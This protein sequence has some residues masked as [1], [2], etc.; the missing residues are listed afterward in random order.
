M[1][2]AGDGLGLSPLTTTNGGGEARAVRVR[3]RAGAREIVESR[4]LA[5][6]ER[7]ELAA[8]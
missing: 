8:R 7:W 5:S 2:A 3:F 6:G 1:S 4:A